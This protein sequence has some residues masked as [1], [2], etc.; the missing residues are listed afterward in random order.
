MKIWKG[1]V[2]ILK[3]F[4]AVLMESIPSFFFFLSLHNGQLFSFFFPSTLRLILNLH[5]LVIHRKW[6][7]S[8]LPVWACHT[9]RPLIWPCRQRRALFCFYFFPLF[10]CSFWFSQLW[11]DS[12][13]KPPPLILKMGFS[14]DMALYIFFIYTVYSF[15]FVPCVAVFLV[16]SSFFI[17]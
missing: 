14:Y 6:D 17:I 2:G 5:F 9:Y 4:P 8:Q 7:R 13:T 3:Y 15:P 12:D 10:P 11:F 16:S 1:E